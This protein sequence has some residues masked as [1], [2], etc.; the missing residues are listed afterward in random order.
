MFNLIYLP[1]WI[2]TIGDKENISFYMSFFILSTP[3]GVIFG[4]I[5]TA[6]VLN[7]ECGWQWAFYIMAVNMMGVAVVM[8]NFNINY[9]NYDLMIK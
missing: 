7:S 2:N 4:Y 8:A 5:I 3:L 9:V 1:V 6:I